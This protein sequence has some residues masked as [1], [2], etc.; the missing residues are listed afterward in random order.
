MAPIVSADLV[1]D[2][3]HVGLIHFLRMDRFC[4]QYHYYFTNQTKDQ[5]L[6]DST[7]TSHQS[8]NWSYLMDRISGS[9]ESTALL[10]CG[11]YADDIDCS[12]CWAVGLDHRYLPLATGV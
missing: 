2:V 3:H 6:R 4:Y 1:V 7:G 10:L 8:Q 5:R 9:S 12:Y 11:L